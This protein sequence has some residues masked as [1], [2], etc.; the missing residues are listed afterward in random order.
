[1]SLDPIASNPDLYHVVFENTRVRVLEYADKPGDKSTPHQHPDSVMVTL[2]SF[3]RRLAAGGREFETELPSGT[4]VWIP[5]QSHTGEN[6]GNTDTR[7]ILIELKEPDPNPAAR[8]TG[9]RDHDAAGLNDTQPLGP[10][11]RR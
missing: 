2:S 5:A 6:I 9:S 10:E 11:W 4:A 7:T 3:S 1:M 8:Q